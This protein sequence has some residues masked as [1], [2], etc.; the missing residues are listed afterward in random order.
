MVAVNEVEESV[1]MEEAIFPLPSVWL[2]SFVFA[3]V[4]EVEKSR[5]MDKPPS[6]SAWMHPIA[7]AIVVATIIGS[8]IGL[9]AHYLSYNLGNQFETIV[10][11]IE[12]VVDVKATTS[13]TWRGFSTKFS[14]A[15]FCFGCKS[16]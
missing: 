12:V 3:I 7:F 10:F 2:R 13:F 11:N 9:R 15:G 1:P 8:S 5:P 16:H 4:H 14:L 6:Q